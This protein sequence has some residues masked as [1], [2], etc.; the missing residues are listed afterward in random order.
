MVLGIWP[1]VP[2]HSWQASVLRLLAVDKYALAIVIK[3]PKTLWDRIAITGQALHRPGP[4]V[5]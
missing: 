2:N 4:D 5:L 3:S 1:R